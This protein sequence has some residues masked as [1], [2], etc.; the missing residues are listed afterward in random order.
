MATHTL[1][2]L[3]AAIIA[4]GRKID[5]LMDVHYDKN[6]VVKSINILSSYKDRLGRLQFHKWDIEGK[7]T[8]R[9]GDVAYPELN[10]F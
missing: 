5:A 10:L 2:E 7:C 9:R 6:G 3:E 1:A 4:K 8:S